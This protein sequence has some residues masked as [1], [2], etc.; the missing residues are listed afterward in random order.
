MIRLILPLII[1]TGTVWL[2]FFAVSRR[3]RKQ[4]FGIA[5]RMGIAF[6][7]SAIVLATLSLVFYLGGLVH[8]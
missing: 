7:A 4:A 2:T 3:G 1:I 8:G 5:G 6:A